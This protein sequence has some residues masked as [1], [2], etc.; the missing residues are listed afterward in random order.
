MHDGTIDIHY[1]NWN[2]YVFPIVLPFCNSPDIMVIHMH[3]VLSGNEYRGI[4]T[5]HHCTPI[6]S[7]LVQC[8][9]DIH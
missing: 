3:F 9:F 6:I 8:A 7:V 4:C 1:S 5:V 2:S